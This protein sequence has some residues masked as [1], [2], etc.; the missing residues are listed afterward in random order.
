MKH[1][2]LTNLIHAENKSADPK[3]GDGATLIL[4]S[5]RHAY[6]IISVKKT[7]LLATRDIAERT[8]QNFE[9]GP[10]EYTY[11]IDLEALPQR[12]NRRKDGNFYIGGQVLKVGYRNEYR[13]PNF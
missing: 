5:D 9:K 6:T 11:H 10:Q 2:S 13:D 4:W 7:Y 3:V 8:D 1:G 12:A